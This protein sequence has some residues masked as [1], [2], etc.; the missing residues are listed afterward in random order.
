MKSK[1]GGV[2]VHA[3]FM[4]STSRPAG[5]SSLKGCFDGTQDRK[6]LH[7]RAFQAEP[8]A[9]N[10]CHDIKCF[11]LQKYTAAYRVMSGMTFNYAEIDMD[12][13]LAESHFCRRH[14]LP[15]HN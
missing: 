12:E 15:C 1:N 4:S 5:L 8:Q 11:L 14:T 3:A 6:M 13:K 2:K 7:P 9:V 10:S